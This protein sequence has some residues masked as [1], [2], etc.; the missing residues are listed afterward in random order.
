[1]MRTDDRSIEGNPESSETAGDD[2][3]SG[4]NAGGTLSE[5]V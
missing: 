4:E 2:I 1:M 3:A 5:L